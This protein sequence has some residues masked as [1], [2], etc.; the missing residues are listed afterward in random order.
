MG[1][2]Y[3]CSKLCKIDFHHPQMC[4]HDLINKFPHLKFDPIIE[5]H[6]YMSQHLSHLCIIKLMI[7]CFFYIY[8]EKKNVED[9]IEIMKILGYGDLGRGP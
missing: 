4:F 5:T 2:F 7:F 3:L 1:R 6:L 9:N 8:R